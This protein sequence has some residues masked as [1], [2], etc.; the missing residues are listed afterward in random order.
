MDQLS[1][2]LGRRATL[3]DTWLTPNR[4][5]ADTWLTLGW[6]QASMDQLS[7]DLGRRATLASQEGR[8]SID[9]P[10]LA[11][12]RIERTSTHRRDIS[13]YMKRKH[14]KKKNEISAQARTS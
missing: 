6:Y 7:R 12:E 9:N 4:H 14:E 5:L 8:G 2:D 13:A 10:I 1:W 3:V 11:G